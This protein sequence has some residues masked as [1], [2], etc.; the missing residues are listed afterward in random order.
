MTRRERVSA[1]CRAYRSGATVAACSARFAVDGAY[2][3]AALRARAVP[4]RVTGPCDHERLH[5][6]R[7]CTACIVA[8]DNALR[9]AQEAARVA[10]GRAATKRRATKRRAVGPVACCWCSR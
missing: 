8:R 10:A 6:S 1:I 3:L 4:L 5:A 9:A 7:P 2:V